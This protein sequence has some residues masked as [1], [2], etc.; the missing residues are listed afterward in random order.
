MLWY[1]NSNPVQLV[2]LITLLLTGHKPKKLDKLKLWPDGG[3][4][5]KVKGQVSVLRPVGN[6][7]VWQTSWQ[8]LRYFSLD[9]SDGPWSH[10]TCVPK[11]ENIIYIIYYM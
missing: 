6:V 9:Q 11:N 8:L 7:T 2:T 4:R 1:I 10:A 3:A 5:W